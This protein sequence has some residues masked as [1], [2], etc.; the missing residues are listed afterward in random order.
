VSDA[1]TTERRRKANAERAQKAALEGYNGW[2]NYETWCVHLWLDNDQGLQE[3][4][5]FLARSQE[6]GTTA[7]ERLKTWVEEDLVPDLGASF[8]ADLLGTALSEVNW[9]EVA[10][11]FRED[12]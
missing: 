9:T 2:D 12:Q 7:E 10:E 8:A 11:A 3:Q 4:A 6:S 1:S 5:Q